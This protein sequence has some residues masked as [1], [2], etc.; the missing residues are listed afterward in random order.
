MT[1]V[2]WAIDKLKEIF[3]AKLQSDKA[4]ICAEQNWK[5]I[6]TRS[7]E[8][9]LVVTERHWWGGFSVGRFVV[10]QL[11]ASRRKLTYTQIVS[12]LKCRAAGSRA[13]EL[14]RRRVFP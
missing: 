3:Q 6:T 14:E 2:P 5:R 4:T 7:L 8:S 12:S 10:A 9:S 1:S 11:I 13:R